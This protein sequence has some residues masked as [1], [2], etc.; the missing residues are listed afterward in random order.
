MAPVR[1]AHDGLVFAAITGRRLGGFCLVMAVVLAGRIGEL[2]AVVLGQHCDPDGL[3]GVWNTPIICYSHLDFEEG[4][5]HKTLYA[6]RAALPGPRV[7]YIRLP[8]TANWAHR[9]IR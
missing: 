7:M 9:V 5:L 6:P 8:A 2:L 4:I 3:A 1:R